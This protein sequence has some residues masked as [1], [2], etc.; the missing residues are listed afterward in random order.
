MTKKAKILAQLIE[1]VKQI[2]RDVKS[3]WC[4]FSYEAKKRAVRLLFDTLTIRL[5][6]RANPGKRKKAQVKIVGYKL[7]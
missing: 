3:E 7:N 4:N 5:V 2:I 1:Q 6:E